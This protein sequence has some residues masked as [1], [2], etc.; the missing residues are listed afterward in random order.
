M[1]EVDWLHEIESALGDE[2][3]TVFVADA[4]GVLAGT[5]R[6]EFVARPYGRVAD[7]R[8]L[9]VSEPWR[10][11]GIAT[12]LMRAAEQFA[13]SGDAMEIR[14]MVLTGSGP[15]QEL[16]ERRGY[17]QYAARLRKVLQ[18]APD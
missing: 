6:L 14:L 15:A 12:R 5:V 8:R 3:A 11:R 10:R 1:R 7:V 17:R 16:C 13:S 4:G 9:F 2:H 18:Q